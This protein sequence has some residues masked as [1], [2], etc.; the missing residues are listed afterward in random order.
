[1]CWE[2]RFP[3]LKIIL[4]TLKQNMGWTCVDLSV[5]CSPQPWGHPTPRS[6]SPPHTTSPIRVDGPHPAQAPAGPSEPW[7]CPPTRG[8]ALPRPPEDLR[9]K[10][11]RRGG[12]RGRS[13]FTIRWNICAY[14]NK[15]KIHEQTP[16][17]FF[18]S[19]THTQCQCK[20][21]VYMCHGLKCVPPD[22]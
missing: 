9:T 11:F 4:R 22:S 14:Y 6:G 15:I 8:S 19:I 2:C 1:M 17:T 3:S 16:M 10:L 20:R 21:L 12:G 18:T 7:H 13:L 5:T